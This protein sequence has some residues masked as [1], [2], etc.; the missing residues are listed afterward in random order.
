MLLPAS[1]SDIKYSAGTLSHERMMRCIELF[2]REV[3]PR[4]R[5]LLEPGAA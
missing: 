5:A 1:R 4:V 2:G 3:A